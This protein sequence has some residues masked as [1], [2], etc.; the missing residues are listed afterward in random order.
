MW[1]RLG[2]VA[3][4]VAFVGSSALAQGS[5]APARNKDSFKVTKSLEGVVKEVQEAEGTFTLKDPENDKEYVLAIDD[6][7]VVEGFDA[8]DLEEGMKLRV[9]YAP[10]QEEGVDGLAT[11]IRRI[12]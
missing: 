4:F 12:K 9:R 7:T 2:L 3:L 5:G 6:T 11:R 8:S 1:S 10:L